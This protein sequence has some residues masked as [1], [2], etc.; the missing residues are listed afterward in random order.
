LRPFFSIELV[1]K[2]P[3]WKL[4][5]ASTVIEKA[6]FDGIWVSEHFFN[7]NSLVSLSTIALHTK[8]VIVGPAVLNP[9]TMHPLLIAQ[10]AASLWELAPHRV[11]V[12]VGAGDGLAEIGV[13][14]EDVKGG[15]R[16]RVVR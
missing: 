7:R 10:A 13:V 9:Y 8:K 14:V 1:P 16:V 3:L 2:D 4:A 15:E 6:G 5:I 11:R 12:A